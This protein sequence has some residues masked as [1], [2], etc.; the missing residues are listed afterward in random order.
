MLA[1]LAPPELGSWMERK[2]G[3]PRS[4]VGEQEKIIKFLCL[5]YGDVTKWNA[6]SKSK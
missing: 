5:A 1:A 6:L 3:I 2:L 4:I